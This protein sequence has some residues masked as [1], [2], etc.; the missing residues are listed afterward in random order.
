MDLKLYQIDAFA[1]QVFEGNSA[2]VCPLDEWLADDLMQ[3]IA[4]ENNLAE[5]AFFVASNDAF[6]IRWFSPLKEVDLCGHATLASAYVLFEKLAYGK[7]EISFNSRSGILK[8]KRVAD[9][10]ELD[11]PVQRPV[12]CDCPEPLLAAFGQPIECLKAEDYILFFEDEQTVLEANP[13]LSLLLEVDLRAVA[14]TARSKE[15]DF[16]SRLFAPKYGISEDPVTGSLY[17]QL[18]P[19]WSEKFNKL[20]LSAKQ[21]S[22]RTG[23]VRCALAGDRV[24]ILGKAVAYMDGVITI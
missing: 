1:S 13:D 3:K 6:D 4:E 8:V 18:T 10:F 24:K 11:F 22:A 19:Y 17:T 12:P 2:A 7:P 15:Y 20:A 9:W 14:I 16:V 21:V 23:E 5:T